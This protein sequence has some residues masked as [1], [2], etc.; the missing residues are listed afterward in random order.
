MAKAVFAVSAL[1]TLFIAFAAVLTGNVPA[2][3]LV[4]LLLLIFVFGIILNIIAAK[5]VSAELDTVESSNGGEGIEVSVRLRN[6]SILPVFRGQLKISAENINF[7]FRTVSKESFSIR[8]K[9]IRTVTMHVR[10]NYCGQYRIE[11]QDVKCVDL[12]GLT[13]KRVKAHAESLACMFPH[14]YSIG[15]VTEAV[16][17]NYEKEKKFAGRKSNILSDILQY[18]EYQ[19]GDSLKNVNWK[20][21]VKHDQLLVREF[22]TPIDNQ[23][24]VI[25]DING[26]DAK[27]Q[28]MTYEVM[29]SI[30]LEYL[31]YNISHQICW[32][33]S[34]RLE[35]GHVENTDDLLRHMRVILSTPIDTAMPAMGMFEAQ[36][37]KEKYAK[38]LYITNG[39]NSAIEHRIMTW[40]NAEVITVNDKYFSGEDPSSELKRL[41]V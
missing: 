19:K 33:D 11:L 28:N 15:K 1:I 6:D 8:P 41:A 38:I 24:M 20:L 23:L 40:G 16:K 32:P 35:S 5:K 18:R 21:S 25:L 27:Y 13:G 36:D 29:F 7:G 2:A 4:I 34:G 14:R 22:D 30:C 9:E 17:Q 12:W 10:S 39:V 31:R 37:R 26:G 3:V